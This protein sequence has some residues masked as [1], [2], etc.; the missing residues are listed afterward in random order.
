MSSVDESAGVDLFPDTVP[1]CL[2]YKIFKGKIQFPNLFHGEMYSAEL[3][4]GDII[5]AGHQTGRG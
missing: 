5:L 2:Y 4:T 1:G 3:M